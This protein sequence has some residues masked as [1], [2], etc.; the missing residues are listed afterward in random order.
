MARPSKTLEHHCRDGSFRADRHATMLV[1]PLVTPRRLRALQIAYRETGKQSEKRRIALEFAEETRRYAK[2]RRRQAPKA[3]GPDGAAVADFFARHFRHTKG[4][5]AG[6]RFELEPWQRE[7]VDEFYRRDEQ[8]RR[9]YRLGILG[10]PR[11][12][13]K[14]PLAA[15]LGLYELVTRTDSPD[16]F[17]AAASRDQGRIVF[18]YGRSFV[19]SGPLSSLVRTGRNELIYEDNLGAMRVL[20][21]EG[22][23]QHGLSVSCAIVDELHAFTTGKQEEL[24][25]ALTTA[26]HKRED[27]FALAITTAGA[28]RETLLGR[29]YD[30]A[31]AKLELARPHDCLT[32]GRDEENGT[33]M[34]WYAAPE[35]AALEDEQAWRGANPASWVDLRDLR[36]QR[37]APGSSEASFR[38]LHLNQFTSGEEV[39]ITPER[40][41]ACEG[42]EEIPEDA[43]TYIG[44]DASWTNDA[45][46]VSV[47]H[48]LRDDRVV[49]RCHVWS[50][51][52]ETAAH[53]RV[54]GGR[55]DFTAVEDYILELAHRYRVREV[56]F[57]PDFF[58]RSSELLAERGLT[59][60]PIDQRSKAMREAY[61]QFYE[62]V[63]AR[64]IVHNG[65]AV[66]ASHVISA[67][68]TLDE[69]GSWRIKKVKQS[70]KIDGLVASVIAYSRAAREQSSIYE[71]RELVLI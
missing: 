63:G 48:R 42:E 52:E 5:R 9:I 18:N 40:W 17:C 8:G 3:Q 4:A 24:W 45:T 14:S 27:S 15:G 44:V 70:R 51:L 53:S 10:I 60:A 31:L 61:S 36:R 62:A 71:E 39:W 7:F 67:A 35:A 46:A 47:A 32:I 16:V 26:L 2:T 37:N 57:D 12:N 49:L 68:A 23:V 34:Y 6:K 19:E 28:G 33:L 11:G 59:V 65:D 43:E 55:I 25:T 58:A 69:Y 38:R 64:Q 41:A 20:S 66:L 30:E 54:P 13:G 56:V 21:S 29:M 50:A 22:L 1:G